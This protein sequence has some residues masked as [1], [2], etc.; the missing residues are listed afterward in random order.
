MAGL[1]LDLV[2]THNK[3]RK[4]KGSRNTAIKM[5]GVL[6]NDKIARLE[7]L[8]S[9]AVSKKREI[10]ANA[11]RTRVLRKIAM[12]GIKISE[13]LPD[14]FLDE[15]DVKGLVGEM[16]LEGLILSRGHS[17]VYVKWRNSGTSHSNGLD[18][19]ASDTHTSKPK[20]MIGESKHIHNAIKSASPYI[21]IKDKCVEALEQS[22]VNHVLLSLA[23]ILADFAEAINFQE[24][25]KGDTADLEPKF[26]LLKD[27]LENR[28]YLLDLS[29]FL[30]ASY[31]TTDAFDRS[32]D[33][34]PEYGNDITVNIAGVETLENTTQLMCEK[35]AG[36][37]S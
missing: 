28:D 13:K 2:Y 7:G 9:E 33:G 23:R 34:L 4:I 22:D 1:A 27:S 25:V 18:I 21:V 30:D 12:H 15:A 17:V 20:L 3:T 5:C 11:Y 32:M 36:P 8:L 26:L 10:K 6:D 31:C 37:R 19:I 35:F 14:V 29:V 16:L 24:A